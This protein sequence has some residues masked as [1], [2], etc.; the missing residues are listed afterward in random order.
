ME[1]RRIQRELKNR[2]KGRRRRGNEAEVFFAPKSA[3]LRRRLPFL[4][5]PSGGFF[6]H[7]PKKRA[8]EHKEWETITTNRLTGFTIGAALF[9]LVVFASESGFVFLI[10][11]ANLLF[12][13]AGHPI[14][15]LLSTKLEPYGGTIGQL[16]FPLVLTVSFWRKGEPLSFAASVIWFFENWLNIAR[17]MAD[18]R[19]Q[20]LPLVGGGDH[21]W[22]TILGRWHVLAYDTRIAAVV[23]TIGWAG[24]AASCGWVVWRWYRD[25]QR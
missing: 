21:D 13:E 15:G 19:A 10:D 14:V 11:Y 3:S 25:R 7:R 9:A 1:I 23:K 18:A 24:M 17:Y 2:R 8:M 20:E 5:T 12:H 16:V 22:N 4:N 6:R